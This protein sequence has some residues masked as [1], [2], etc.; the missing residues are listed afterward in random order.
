MRLA[1]QSGADSQPASIPVFAIV[2]HWRPQCLARLITKD[3]VPA[4][5]GQEPTAGGTENPNNV[6]ARLPE[7]VLVLVGQS[8]LF[9]YRIEYRKLQ[10]PI[11]ANQSG[12]PIPYQ[13][14]TNPMV[15]LELT[16]VVFDVP[17]EDTGKF[18]YAPGDVEWTDQTATVL[19]RLRQQRN[20]Q[21]AGRSATPLK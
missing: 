3:D 21:L 18:D 1:S 4:P 20:E 19:E 7:E 14:S 6:P 2:G 15:V 5:T 17:I 16:D 9:P 8:D 11:A 10:T 13:L 12:T